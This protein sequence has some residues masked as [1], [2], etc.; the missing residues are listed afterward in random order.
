MLQEVPLPVMISRCSCTQTACQPYKRSVS[1]CHTALFRPS[2]TSYLQ[3]VEHCP[4]IRYSCPNCKINNNDSNLAVPFK[5][6]KQSISSDHGVFHFAPF[7]I[8]CNRKKENLLHSKNNWQ[9]QSVGRFCCRLTWAGQVVMST[10]LWDFTT[11]T[12]V[13]SKG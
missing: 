3:P 9:T 12:C 1:R 10:R 2:F 5:L 4:H 6:S 8:R 7:Q 11:S 13:S